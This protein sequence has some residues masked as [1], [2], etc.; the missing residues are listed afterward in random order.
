[1]KHGS[2]L[3]VDGIFGNNTL[4]AVKSFQKSR[5]LVV[6]GVVGPKTWGALD[7]A[8]IKVLPS[9][10]PAV[11]LPSLPSTPILNIPSI[12]ESGADTSAIIQ[13]KTIL[14]AWSKTDGIVEA[15][16]SDYGTRSE[17]LSTTFG[18][19]DKFVLAS[20]CR[21]NNKTQ[22]TS[23]NTDG[24]L[25]PPVA[26]ALRLWAE[27]K[28]SVV[29]PSVSV[30]TTSPGIVPISTSLPTIP[31]NSTLPAVVVKPDGTIVT[32]PQDTVLAQPTAGPKKDD[33]LILAAG[34]AGLGYLM[35][36][37]VGALIGAAAGALPSLLGGK[38][39]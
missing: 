13:A 20:F 17:D 14:V 22:G 29:T 18:T 2:G 37:P 11:V 7:A 19:R 32:L 6:D 21:W 10:S 9:T 39:A 24:D 28:S 3:K 35:A 23:L 33:T 16:L 15:G 30:P 25:T 38:T 36:G 34:G 8:P 26:D 4:S 31:T 5:G 27:K 12:G 1:M